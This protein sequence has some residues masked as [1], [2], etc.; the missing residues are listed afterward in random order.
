MMPRA[1]HVLWSHRDSSLCRPPTARWNRHADVATKSLLVS[2]CA[3]LHKSAVSSQRPRLPGGV[4]TK[5]ETSCPN[6]PI[7]LSC[8]AQTRVRNTY[9]ACHGRWPLLCAPVLRPPSTHSACWL[10]LHTCDW[11][12]LSPRPARDA[13]TA[14]STISFTCWSRHKRAMCIYSLRSRGRPRPQGQAYLPPC[15]RGGFLRVSCPTAHVQLAYLEALTCSHH[16]S[17]SVYSPACTNQ[18]SHHGGRRA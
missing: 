5:A 6:P 11:L 14:I 13:L 9:A 10:L 16:R 15:T 12:K 3:A 7:R 17:S 1:V 2:D 8:T 18:S 4:C